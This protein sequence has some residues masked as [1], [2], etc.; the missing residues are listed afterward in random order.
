MYIVFVEKDE[1]TFSLQC[2]FSDNIV[3][4][5]LYFFEDYFYDLRGID[6]AHEKN[7]YY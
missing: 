5:K 1:A 6:R 4:T 7:I 2:I 3:S